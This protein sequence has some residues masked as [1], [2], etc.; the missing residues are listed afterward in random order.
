[1]DFDRHLRPQGKKIISWSNM[2]FEFSTMRTWSK[3]GTG[4]NLALGRAV[5]KFLDWFVRSRLG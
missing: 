2:K 1:L 5:R 3:L 4:F